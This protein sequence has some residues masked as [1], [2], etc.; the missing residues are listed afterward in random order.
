MIQQRPTVRDFSF[1]LLNSY[2]LDCVRN[3]FNAGWLTPKFKAVLSNNGR[4]RRSLRQDV[5]CHDILSGGRA[6]G[7][8]I[9]EWVEITRKILLK[10][11]GYSTCAP[12]P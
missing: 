4:E 10:D 2:D 5:A 11:A 6:A 1:I 8:C 12:H 3:Q 9:Q 7:R